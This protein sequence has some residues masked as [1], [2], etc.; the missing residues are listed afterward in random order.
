MGHIPVRGQVNR[1]IPPRD[2]QP[3]LQEQTICSPGSQNVFNG[4]T[5]ANGKSSGW[6][7]A[8]TEQKT[9]GFKKKV[10]IHIFKVI[11]HVKKSTLQIVGLPNSVP[12]TSYEESNLTS[13]AI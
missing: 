6:G 2:T 12:N 1:L 13:M 7:Q 9:D 4:T 5:T 8:E 3:G 10:S 11:W